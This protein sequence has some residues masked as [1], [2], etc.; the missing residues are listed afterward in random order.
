MNTPELRYFL[1]RLKDWAPIPARYNDPLS[2]HINNANAETQDLIRKSTELVE[3]LL[4]LAEKA[5]PPGLFR[6]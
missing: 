6:S 3:D 5:A 2:T 1:K 4:R